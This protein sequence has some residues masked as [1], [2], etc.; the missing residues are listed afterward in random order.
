MRLFSHCIKSFPC[1]AWLLLLAVVTATFLSNS[2]LLCV[3]PDY[4]L[5]SLAGGMA[6]TVEKDALSQG[7]QKSPGKTWQHTRLSVATNGIDFGAD[8][9]F[10]YTLCP[11]GMLCADSLALP[12]AAAGLDPVTTKG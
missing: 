12:C 9:L 1:W 8:T 2:T 6:A 3:A 5:M 11:D 7:V 4:T 10:S